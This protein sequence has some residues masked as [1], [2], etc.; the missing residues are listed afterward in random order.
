MMR[1]WAFSKD[2]DLL[3]LCGATLQGGAC[4]L[5]LPQAPPGPLALLMFLGWLLKPC[6]VTI[7]FRIL[8]LIIKTM[9]KISVITSYLMLLQVKYCATNNIH[10]LAPVLKK[11]TKNKKPWCLYSYIREKKTRDKGEWYP[12]AP[13]HVCVRLSLLQIFLGICYMLC[14]CLSLFSFHWRLS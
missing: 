3:E 4:M 2:R 14:I 8:L 9:I 10:K 1:R 11:K 5:S 12:H 13:F 7:C 6:E